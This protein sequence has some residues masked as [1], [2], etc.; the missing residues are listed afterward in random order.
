MTPTPPIDPLLNEFMD[1]L[2]N[3][4]ETL[5]LMMGINEEI[6]TKGIPEVTKIFYTGTQIICE[7]TGAAIATL[8]DALGLEDDLQN[9]DINVQENGTAVHLVCEMPMLDA[10][11][12]DWTPQSAVVYI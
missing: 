3:R 6:K 2:M 1:K 10:S 7:V 4:I 9:Y 8:R 12:I 11:K 5:L